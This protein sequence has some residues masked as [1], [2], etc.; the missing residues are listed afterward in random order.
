VARRRPRPVSWRPIAQGAHHGGT[1]SQQAQRRTWLLRALRGVGFSG[2][3]VC[4]LVWVVGS[5][6]WAARRELRSQAGAIQT[7]IDLQTQ[8]LRGVVARYKHIP[9]TTAQFARCTRPAA[10][11]QTRQLRC[12]GLTATCKRSIAR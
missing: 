4:A 9:F 6:E 10:A 2:L 11:G 5:G 3:V 1:H 12:C 8:G 7:T